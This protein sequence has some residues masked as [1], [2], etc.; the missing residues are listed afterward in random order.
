MESSNKTVADF[1]GLVKSWIPWRSG[2]TNVSRDF[3]MPDHS[4]R[5]C[6]HCDTQFTLFTR[7][8]HCRVCG[9]VFCGKCTSN[10]VPASYVDTSDTLYLGEERLRA[11]DYCYRQWEEETTLDCNGSE[12]SANISRSQSEASFSS[13]KSSGS[14]TDRCDIAHQPVPYSEAHPILSYGVVLSPH[15]PAT[16]STIFDR[17]AYRATRRTEDAVTDMDDP[18]FSRGFFTNRYFMLIFFSN[19]LAR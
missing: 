1:I 19:D 3:W 14:G 12:V 2:S 10:T 13:T 11:C 5:V 15:E 9:R 17:H 18:S 7:R 16:L 6:Y 4:C 8:H